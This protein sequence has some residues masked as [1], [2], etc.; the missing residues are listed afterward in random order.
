MN[1]NRK[2]SVVAAIAYITVAWC[3]SGAR[4]A[5]QMGVFCLLPLTFIWFSDTLRLPK[6]SAPPAT[7][8]NPSAGMMIR[9]AGWM[10]MLLPALF[11]LA[12]WCLT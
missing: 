10:I 7:G 12:A 5:F 3:V 8:S 1:W 11:L 6:A 2:L 4:A 9:V